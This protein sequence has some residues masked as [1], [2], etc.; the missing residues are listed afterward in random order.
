MIQDHQGMLSLLVIKLMD[1]LTVPIPT[2][3]TLFHFNR[4]TKAELSIIINTQVSKKDMIRITIRVR[5]Q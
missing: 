3:K 4:V 5:S 1:T 2:T